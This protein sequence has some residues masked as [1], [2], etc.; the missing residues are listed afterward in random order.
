MDSK[1]N[2]SEVEAQLRQTADAMTDRIASL[3]E[4]VESTGTSV[5][6]WVVQ[7]PVK[8][9]GGML[10]AGLVVGLAF[11][12][13]RRKRRKTH[14]KLIDQYLNALTDEV[15]EAQRRGE[16]PSKALDKALRDRVPL[17]VYTSGGRN[18]R[19]SGFLRNLLSESFE[20]VVR[21]AITLFARDAIEAILA[22]SNLDEAIDEDLLDALG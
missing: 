2:K 21:T 10:V 18:R 17:V 8:S 5:R 12:G 11:G 3:R 9:V 20:T 16:E 14:A 15:D 19:E 6:D 13:S 4:E 22:N 7:H 1:T